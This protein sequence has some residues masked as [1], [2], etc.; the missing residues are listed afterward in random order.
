M[1]RPVDD[2]VA[3]I[4]A[5]RASPRCARA[6]EVLELLDLQE[7]AHRPSSQLPTGVRRMAELACV[8]ALQPDVLLLDEP[9]AG[10]TPR[11]TEAFG[12]TIEDVRRH[13][14]ATIVIIDHDVRLM[15]DLVD[16]LYVLAAGKVIAEG[17]PSMLDT[18]TRRRR[19][20]PRGL[21]GCPHR[22][23]ADAR[24]GRP[25]LTRAPIARTTSRTRRGSSTTCTAAS[26]ANPP[27]NPP[28][29]PAAPMR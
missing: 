20:L 26:A 15:R 5:I 12:E 3:G 29:P 28:T 21:R 16:R 18:D 11:E 9:T 17:P 19:G 4:R 7:Y 13:L 6:A 27:E 25:G 22:P 8:I 10:Y 2:R 14:G 1:A 23:R 24:S